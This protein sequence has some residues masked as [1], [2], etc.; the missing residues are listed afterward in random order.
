MA[1]VSGVSGSTSP[2]STG[3]YSAE[4]TDKNI[5]NITSYFKLLSAQLASQD[6]TNPMDNS[7]LLAQMSQMAMVQS[8]TSMTKA[9]DS[10]IDFA[11]QSYSVGMI[12][13]EVTVL[14]E[15]EAG[16]GQQTT[17][18]TGIVESVH[19]TDDEPIIRLQ[20]DTTD[21]K[22]SDI[23]SIKNSSGSSAAGPSPVDTSPAGPS[24]EEP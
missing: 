17:T 3:S 19:L 20:N 12:G 11:Q 13:K 4:T 21:Y 9:V 8:L 15:G 14:V 1:D 24:S 18:K 16:S 6:M 5:L 23:A 7:E 10:Q 2:Y 22:L